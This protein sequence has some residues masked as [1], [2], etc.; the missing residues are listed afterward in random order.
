MA[1]VINAIVKYRPR[2]KQQQT[3]KERDLAKFIEGRTSINAGTILNV[4]YEIREA[5]IYFHRN[6][7]A[8]KLEGLGTFSP[9][10]GL[11][12]RIRVVHRPDKLIKS[13][14]NVDYRFQATV[15]NKDMIGKTAEELVQRWNDE[16]PDDPIDEKGKNKKKK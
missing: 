1:K 3:V 11:N 5:M 7:E 6:G 14:L 13:E 8:V 2:I 10:I 16:H 9:E 15:V 12:G 4:L